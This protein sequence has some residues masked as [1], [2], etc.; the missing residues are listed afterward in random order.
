MFIGF[1]KSSYIRIDFL[2]R[3]FGRTVCEFDDIATMEKG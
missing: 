3:F 2:C 1:P